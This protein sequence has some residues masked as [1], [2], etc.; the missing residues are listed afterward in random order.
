M[1]STPAS[2]RSGYRPS[3]GSG[4]RRMNFSSASPPATP[5]A[6]PTAICSDELGRD[7]PADRAGAAARREQRHQQRDPDR[8]VGAGLA[9]QQ[10]A[11]C[12]RRS[13]GGPSTENTTA[14]SVGGHAP[15]PAAAPAASPARTTKCA[16]T[17]AA[18][19]VT[20]VPATPTTAI[21]AGRGAEPPPADVHPAVE[22]D[23]RQRHG[24]DPRDRGELQQRH[25]RPQLRRH[26]R[27]DEEEGGSRD[28]QPRA[29]PV[30]EHRAGS[31]EADH[32]DDEPELVGACHWRLIAGR[33]KRSHFPHLTGLSSG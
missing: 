4:T 25:P 1:T 14:G 10:D 32:Q 13:R 31:H 33:G 27:A 30:R 26:A 9:F 5:M 12:A 20:N 7:V 8:V 21:A 18:A 29:Q 3:L 28:A 2:T 15:C 6:A 19:A 24:D 22:Q 23:D 16:A 11:R 17:A